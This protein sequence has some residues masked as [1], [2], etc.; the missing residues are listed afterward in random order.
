MYSQILIDT[1]NVTGPIF[2]IVLLGLALRRLGFIDDAFVD[3]SSRLVFSIC[4]PILLFTTIMRIDFEATFDPQLIAFG[5]GI[6]VVTF[7]LAWVAALP[8]QPRADRGVFIQGAFR[9]NLG[10][11]GLALSASAY[12]TS[13]LALASL[14]MAVCTIVYNVLSVLVLSVYAN[15]RFE[16]A[17]VL[18]DVARNPLILAIIVA[19]ILALLEVPIPGIVMSTGDYIGSLALPLALIGTGASMSLKTLRDSSANTAGVVLLKS[20]LLPLIVVLAALGVGIEGEA[21]GVLFL[22]F[23]SPTANASYIMVKAMGGNDRFAANIIMVTTLA[24]IVT[25]SIG[26]FLLA[27]TGLA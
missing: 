21:L 19:T 14:L 9:S 25:T 3:T 27:M 18:M 23:V 2:L 13:G 22:L 1:V 4:L 20:M 17:R 16:P 11:V 26:L 24:G 12:G 5:I 8:V 6:S 7:L 10:V 15:A